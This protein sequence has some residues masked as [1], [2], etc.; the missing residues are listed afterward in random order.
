MAKTAKKYQLE[1]QRIH[2]I[3]KM[4]V[5]RMSRSKNGA[6][7]SDNGTLQEDRR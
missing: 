6:V 5:T 3:L 4:F 1:L 2:G 7:S